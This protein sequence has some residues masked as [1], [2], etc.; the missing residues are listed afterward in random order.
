MWIFK[1]IGKP[2]SLHAEG[3]YK[4]EVMFPKNYPES[5]FKI[6]FLKPR[7]YHRAVFDKPG[8]S[9]DDGRPSVSL[10]YDW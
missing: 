7:P 2:G 9:W 5:K 1:L 10:D 8:D 6:R 3:I 4:F